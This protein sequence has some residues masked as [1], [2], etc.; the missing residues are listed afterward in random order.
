MIRL[1]GERIPGKERIWLRRG[2]RGALPVAAVL[3]LIC[4]ISACTGPGTRVDPRTMT[5]P[6]L[7][8]N[9][10]KSERLQLDNGMVV[11]LMTDQE[12]PL[13]NVTAYIKTASFYDPE[14]KVGLA[15]LTGAVMRSGGTQQTPGEKLDA[16][17]EFLA[18]TVESSIGSDMGNVSLT[19]LK[20]NLPRT[21][22]LFGQVMMQPLFRED[23]VELARKRTIEGLRRQNDDPKEIAGREFTRALYRGHP[24]A[25]VPTIESLRRITRDD[26]V[27]F[28]KRYYHPNN[29]ILAVSGDIDREEL[30]MRLGKVFNGWKREEIVFPAVDPPRKELKP[31]VLFAHKDVNQSVLRL[32]SLGIEKSNPDLYAL[33]VMNYILGG[34]FTSRL[35]QEVRSNQGLAYQAAS[36]FDVGRRFVGTFWVETETK[37]ESTAKVISLISKIITGMTE[38][39]VSDQELSLA[40]DSII[41]SFIFGFAKPDAVVNQQARLEFFDY[42]SGYLD[43]YRDNIAKVTKEDVLRAAQKYLK[44]DALTITVVG[45]EKRFDGPLS[46]F[47]PVKEIKLEIK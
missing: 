28:H 5:F 35:T 21:L 42:P 1:I 3:L 44:P 16:E 34:G 7:S 4:T 17:L 27:A 40:K 14:D 22:D 13:V 46:M 10:P 41:N 29:V 33:R 8:F 20:K 30:L 6:P 19:T 11:Y 47:G 25:W 2:L 36:Y 32:G 15:G 43:N 12:L 39:A 9:V 37:S 26:M 23:R 18:S 45:N 31:A 38:A 24:L